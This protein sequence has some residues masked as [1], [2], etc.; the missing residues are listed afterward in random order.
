MSSNIPLGTHFEDGLRTGPIY[1]GAVPKEL[2]PFN[3][4]EKLSYAA[5]TAYGPGILHSPQNTWAITPNPA[6][7]DNLVALTT[8]ANI[9]GAM[10]LT[11]RGDNKATRYVGGLSPYVQFDWPRIVTVTV[12]GTSDIGNVRITIF[13][14]DWYNNPIQHTY[15]V[16]ARGTYPVITLGADASITPA[17]KAFYQVTRVWISGS[18]AAN[19][20]LSLGVADVFGLPYLVRNLGDVTTIGWGAKSDLQDNSSLLGTPATGTATLVGGTV[21][22]NCS[23]VTANST[24]QLTGTGAVNAN[25]G[26]W[27]VNARTPGQNFT[28]TSSNNGDTSNVAWSLTNP[29]GQYTA[30]GTSQAMVN[31]SVTVYTS[32]VH[33]QSPIHLTVGT[34]GTAHGRWYVSAINPGVS[35]TVTSTANNE[36]S[37]V[38]W[39]IM[40]ENWSNGTSNAMVNGSVTVSAPEVTA[41]SNILLDYAHFANPGANSGVLSAPS[42]EIIPG[43]G[44]T[45]HSNNNA[46]L[47]RVNW[48]IAQ[49]N[50]GLT[51]GKAT[52]V[53]GTV[54]VNTTAVTDNAIILYTD[55]TVGGA[56]VGTY[57]RTAARVAGTSFTIASQ[58]NA[59]ISTINWQIFSNQFY[60]PQFLYPLGA[61]IPGDRTDPPSATTGDVRGLYAPSTASN[62]RSTLRFTSYVSGADTWIDQIAS[63]QQEQTMN[64][65]IPVTGVKV[66]ALQPSDLYGLPQFYTGNPS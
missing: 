50:P 1:S 13:G 17:S 35:F 25:A 2:L 11:L 49:F 54:V 12:G 5:Y 21:V 34:F 42:A 3:P 56:N 7:Q 57:V 24:I 29:Q 31:G 33:A 16:N 10:N 15:A 61:M 65:T 39:A 26:S 37:T 63:T 52:L 53:A 27:F 4:S 20:T 64:S 46:D 36:T 23:A 14:R 47:N 8:A 45:I 62:G 38:V 18:A 30:T 48:T 66:D 60:L 22:V 43:V 32:Q 28:I 44:F 6:A 40:P 41:D 59:D 9:P 58:N 55:N 51:Q 19:S